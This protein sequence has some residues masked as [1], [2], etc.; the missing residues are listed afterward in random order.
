MSEIVEP[1]A[2]RTP[3]IFQEPW[4]ELPSGYENVFHYTDESS[5]ESIARDGMRHFSERRSGNELTESQRQLMTF[6]THCDQIAE[7]LGME[8]RRSKSVFLALPAN[9]DK[10]NWSRFGNV[11]LEIK[12]DSATSFVFDRRL[13]SLG[14]IAYYKTSEGQ[15]WLAS[16]PQ[17]Q[18]GTEQR[19]ELERMLHEE[20]VE[21]WQYYI[22]K[23]FK[24]AMPLVK[25]ISLTDKERENIAVP[26]VA[27]PS[28]IDPKFI[29][30]VNK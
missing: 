1:R 22:E 11:K 4:P 23:Y 25:Y 16:D 14:A 17:F 30:I 2:N 18:P 15:Q 10:S 19:K 21:D 6:D 9:L 20:A 8:T 24:E 13:H 7:R 28:P 5:L 29:R 27:V 3:K 12:V 26:E